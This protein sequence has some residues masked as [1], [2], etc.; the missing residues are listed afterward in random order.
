MR[1]VVDESVPL[2]DA[3]QGPQLGDVTACSCVQSGQP[4]GDVE[5]G[6]EQSVGRDPGT[7]HKGRYPHSALKE[8]TG[9]KAKECFDG[10]SR[11]PFS[12]QMNSIRMLI[13]QCKNTYPLPARRG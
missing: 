11:V 8:P 12:T 7:H 1:V 4:V 10:P 13:L 2:V 6:V 9:K 3:I 5:V